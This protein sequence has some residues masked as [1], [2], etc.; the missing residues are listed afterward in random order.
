MFFSLLLDGQECEMRS[1]LVFDCDRI[2]FGNRAMCLEYL[3]FR[4][5]DDGVYVQLHLR[6]SFGASVDMGRRSL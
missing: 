1:A 4:G 5:S 6:C 2:V 3:F